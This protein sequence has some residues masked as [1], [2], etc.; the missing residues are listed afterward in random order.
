MGPMARTAI[1]IWG[2]SAGTWTPK[3][4]ELV[5]KVSMLVEI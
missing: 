3:A 2:D 5:C 4:W 1:A